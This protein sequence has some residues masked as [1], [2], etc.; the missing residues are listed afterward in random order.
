MENKE[1]VQRLPITLLHYHTIENEASKID[2]TGKVSYETIA[3]E[4]SK[5]EIKVPVKKKREEGELTK[6]R[7]KY[8]TKFEEIIIQET[9]EDIME[10]LVEL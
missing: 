2:R 5:K 8:V 9:K 10:E 6:E 1:S 4:W 7:R 3:F